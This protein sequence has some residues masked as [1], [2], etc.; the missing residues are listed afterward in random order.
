MSSDFVSKQLVCSKIT[1]PFL[2][3]T[4]NFFFSISNIVFQ[5]IRN[6]EQCINHFPNNPWF[7]RVCRISLLKTMWEK[8]KLLVTSNFS[9]S[10][11]VFYPSGEIPAIFIKFELVVC[12]L[13]QFGEV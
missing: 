8:E 4:L 7:L 3:E 5:S 2:P 13:F 1:N 12:K 11:I 6:T 10:H 9:F